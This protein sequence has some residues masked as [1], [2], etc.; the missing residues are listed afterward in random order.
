MCLF[1]AFILFAVFLF[2]GEEIGPSRRVRRMLS[3]RSALRRFL[4]PGVVPTARLLLFGSVTPLLMLAGAGIVY[5][6]MA[7][8]TSPSYGADEQIEQIVVFSVFSFGFT[9]FLIGLT[10][11]L[12]ARAKNASGPRVL[13]LVTL[14][15]L[16]AGP[17]VLAAMAG[18]MTSGTDSALAV[19]SPSPLYVLVVTLDAI[20]RG[21][22]ASGT[23]TV[24]VLAT[25]LC[26]GIYGV[27][28]MAMTMAA[29]RKCN[30]IIAEHEA[31]LSEADRRLAAEDAEAEARK[32]KAEEDAEAAARAE[33]EKPAPADAP[34]ADEEAAP[35]AQ[36]APLDAP[37]EEAQVA[38]PPDADE[39]A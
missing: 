34:P 8:V 9:L 32:R 22:V 39:P 29:A 30:R 4:A 17:W 15:L 25:L 7:H 27:I 11:F 33:A 5:L 14:F 16:T 31:M 6:S 28:G 1:C 36:R 19:A 21:T 26:A 13:L 18:V 3:Q 38:K 12:R 35:A 20:R 23:K 37:P 2:A 24:P 10:A